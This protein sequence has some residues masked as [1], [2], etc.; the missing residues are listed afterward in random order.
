MPEWFHA[1]LDFFLPC[2]RKEP[3]S[4]IYFSP[5]LF[6]GLED[7]VRSDRSEEHTSELQSR[8][9]LVC[10]L[11]LETKQVRRRSGPRR[12]PR[13]GTPLRPPAPPGLC[14]S[15]A[16]PAGI[17]PRSAPHAP[18]HAPHRPICPEPRAV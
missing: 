15:R 18:A 10:R 14:G 6:L 16:S 11:L 1:L 4:R 3:H 5:S 13:R 8:L 9:H 12:A 2:T 7:F 17:P